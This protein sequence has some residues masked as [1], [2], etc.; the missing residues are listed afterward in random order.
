MGHRL[1]ASDALFARAAQVVPRGIYGTRGPLLVV[2]GSYPL[3][4][5][6]GR[7]ARFWDVDGNEYID[8]MCGFGSIIL[9]YADAEVDAASR[10]AEASGFSFSQPT[11]HFVAL[12]ERLSQQ[13]DGMAWALFT[14]NGS[15][16]T[17]YAVQVARAATGR[18]KVLCARDAYHGSYPW[19]TPGDAGL[20]P[21]DTAHI[22]HFVWNDLG[23]VQRLVEQ[24]RGDIAAAVV[25]PYHH[26][27]FDDSE[28]SANGFL[29]ELC[30][31]ARAEGVL[32]V[33]DDIRVGFRA[34]LR[35]AHTVFD[36]QPDLVCLS[37]AIANGYPLAVC[38]GSEEVRRA[39]SSVF[40][41][42]TFWMHHGPMAAAHAC[43]DRL[44]ASDGVAQMAARGQQLIDGL[45]QVATR[46][47]QRLTI[48]GL[49]AMPKVR[50]VADRD[51]FRLQAFCAA[52]TRRG[53]YFHPHHNWFV[54]TAHSEEDVQ[55]T[56]EIADAAM[57]ETVAAGDRPFA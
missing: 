28:L 23:S 52:A 15:D 56:V 57:A 12:A 40:T 46:H 49:P 54:T 41:T 19:S 16:A 42:G 47:G 8:Y 21:E 48:T 36:Y 39:A 51:M 11:E 9:G 1:A 10:E 6:N 29:Q 7:G 32:I 50:F 37:K 31:L 24:H 14:K 18:R 45:Q 33:S 5:R 30:R 20:L 13:I 3:F 43:M 26:P 22:H 27:A 55:R 2:P 38:L 4:V 25:T 44:A 17:T 53:A 34:S 35:G